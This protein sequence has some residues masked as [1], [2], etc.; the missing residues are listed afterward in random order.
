MSIAW[1]FPGQGSQK[2]GMAKGILGLYESK[3][4][5]KEASNLLGKDLLEICSKHNP[6]LNDKLTS[7]NNTENTQLALFVLETLLVDIL[8][9][10]GHQPQILAGHSLGELT[11]L[12]AAGVFDIRTGLNLVKHRSQL[13]ASENGGA[14]V[15]IIGFDQIQLNELLLERKDI[16]IANDN[17]VSQVVL[18]GERKAIQGIS[19]I[20][21]CKRAIPLIVSGA[22]HSPFMN[23][24]AEA[25]NQVLNATIFRDAKIPVLSN[26]EPIPTRDGSLLK[27]RLQNQMTT[28]V[29][30]RE[31]MEV[32]KNKG[33]DT[34]IELGPGSVLSNL[35][36]RNMKG[37][38]SISINNAGDLGF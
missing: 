8:E 33:V 22:F 2:T 1:I 14:M 21:K 17:S 4:R 38:D 9:L 23:K 34:I 11:A 5:F 13:M 29:R 28:G 26:V 7:L 32:I 12:Y 19:Q 6:D 31:T 37:I 36:K 10:Q 27:Q 24:A 18:S 3:V 16:V 25:F 20:I 35:C 15:A 30:W